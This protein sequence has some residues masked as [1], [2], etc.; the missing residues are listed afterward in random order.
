MIKL[1]AKKY[2]P[3]NN[4]TRLHKDVKDLQKRQILK[5]RKF[6]K[7]ITENRVKH[8]EKIR[9]FLEEQF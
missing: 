6:L 4:P 2:C 3:P 5:K 1:S 7:K 8:A 9:V